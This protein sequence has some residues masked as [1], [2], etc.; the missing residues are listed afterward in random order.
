MRCKKAKILASTAIDGELS[1]REKRLLE[2]HLASCPT[3]RE[4]HAS[5]V[6][7]R[8]TMALWEDEEPS[9]WLA[10][11][12]AHKLEKFMA[13]EKH[14]VIRKSRWA[15]GA[16]TAGLVTALLV[17]GFL[18]TSRPEP[19]MHPTKQPS[20]A[21]TPMP[22]ET[23]E[24]PKPTLHQPQMMATQPSA[25]PSTGLNAE[26]H[27]HNKRKIAKVASGVKP[28]RLES[29]KKVKRNI[30]NEV[31]KE[32]PADM[33]ALSTIIA[34]TKSQEEASIVVASN[35]GVTGMT[36]NEAIE[37]LRG[38]LQKTA[39]ILAERSNRENYDMIMEEGGTL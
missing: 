7:L 14:P 28:S 2:Q 31:P 36:M 34:A 29:T 10:E 26:A 38:T 39:D 22:S 12:F 16:A 3:C 9:P 20:I 5:F 8:E 15:L 1:E 37:I 32:E 25:T 33:A 24:S 19:P 11:N 4:E 18:L 6:T 27:K 30:I 35:L 21:Q 13:E 23:K 17:I